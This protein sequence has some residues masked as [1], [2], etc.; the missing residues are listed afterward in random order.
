MHIHLLCLA[1]DAGYFSVC[2]SVSLS[3]SLSLSLSVYVS[4]SVCQSVVQLMSSA[5][6][7]LLDAIGSAMQSILLTLHDEDFSAMYVHCQLYISFILVV[8]SLIISR[9]LSMS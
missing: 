2:L 9:Y 1:A 3:L 8:C 5:V 4:L 6:E 7:P